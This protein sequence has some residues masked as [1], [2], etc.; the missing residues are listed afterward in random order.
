MGGSSQKPRE[1]IRHVVKDSCIG[2][3]FGLIFD[4]ILDHRVQFPRLENGVGWGRGTT[5]GLWVLPYTVLCLAAS[6]VTNQ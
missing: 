3:V 6:I 4:V 5:D 2:A 1:G